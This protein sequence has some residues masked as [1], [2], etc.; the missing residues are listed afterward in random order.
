[1]TQIHLPNLPSGMQALRHPSNV[2]EFVSRAGD[3]VRVVRVILSTATPR[4]MAY[5]QVGTDRYPMSLFLDEI[6]GYIDMAKQVLRTPS[7]E[8]LNPKP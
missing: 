3:G 7:P 2:V 5:S 8:N 4:V 1:M 6:L